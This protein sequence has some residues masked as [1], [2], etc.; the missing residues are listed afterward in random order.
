MPSKV[1]QSLQI[2]MH[3]F[4]DSMNIIKLEG[5]GDMPPVPGSTPVN[6]RVH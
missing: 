3:C 5:R 4:F 6:G 2:S 1:C